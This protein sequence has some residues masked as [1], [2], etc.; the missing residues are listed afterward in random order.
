M[1]DLNFTDKFR[2]GTQGG[3][4]QKYTYYDD[5]TGVRGLL[6]RIKEA[7]G[8]LKAAAAKICKKK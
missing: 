6:P 2:C 4:E 1:N 7:L 8:K 5:G 3:V